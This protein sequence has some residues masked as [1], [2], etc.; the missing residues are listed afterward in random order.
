MG[1][2]CGSGNNNNS[3][4]ITQYHADEIEKNG[5]KERMEWKNHLITKYLHFNELEKSMQRAM[6]RVF[7]EKCK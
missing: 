2:L 1:L 6:A 4:H 5:E 7:L 3:N